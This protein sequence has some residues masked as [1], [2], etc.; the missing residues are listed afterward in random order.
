MEHTQIITPADLAKYAGTRDSEAVIPE[1]VW[2]LVRQSTSDLITCRIPYGDAINQPGLDGLVET[3]SGFRQFI[4]KKRSLWEIGTGGEPQ[5]KAT[6]DF[7]KRT[8]QLTLPERQGASYIFVTPHAANSGGWSEPAQRKWIE[9]R[10]NDGWKNIKIIDGITLTD[11]LRE[12][13]AIGKWLLKKI[14]PMKANTGLSTPAEHWENM[15]EF[16][17]PD[18][19]SLSPKIFLIGREHACAEMHRL[20]HGEINKLVFAYESPA[21]TEDFVAAFL[22]SLDTETQRS[23]CNRCLFIKDPDV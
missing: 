19:M 2:M 14:G 17:R 11:W 12:F 23:F 13:P 4:P 10:K 20:F 3:E 15:Q 9:N 1:L 5:T 21:D 18:N 16:A 6:E 8:G 7:K 22:A